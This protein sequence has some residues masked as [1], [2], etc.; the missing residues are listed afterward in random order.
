MATEPMTGYVYLR[1]GEEIDFTTERLSEEEIL[2]EGLE[3]MRNLRVEFDDDGQPVALVH[4]DNLTR[5]PI[6]VGEEE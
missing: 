6:A 3:E 2:A 5:V 1:E 4:Q